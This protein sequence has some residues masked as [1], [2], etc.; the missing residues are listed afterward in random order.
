MSISQCDKTWGSSFWV[1]LC[2]MIIYPRIFC[3][4]SSTLIGDLAELFD[5]PYIRVLSFC[6]QRWS[7]HSK[8]AMNT[9]MIKFWSSDYEGPMSDCILI[10][11]A[12]SN[13][14]TKCH[15]CQSS[16]LCFFSYL[17]KCP[18]IVV[19]INTL[20]FKR[21]C[22]CNHNCYELIKIS[23]KKNTEW[24]RPYWNLMKSLVSK[25]WT[26]VLNLHVIT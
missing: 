18:K 24:K 23:E 3:F 1:M 20:L 26:I 2:E 22:F 9:C 25:I 13:N 19:P 10:D 8:T 11:S 17:M 6:K 7:C 12:I 21:H 16:C 14:Y 5:A 15:T 4:T